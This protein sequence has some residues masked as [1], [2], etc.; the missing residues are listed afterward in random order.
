M[1]LVVTNFYMAHVPLNAS[2]NL[3]VQ[4]AGVYAV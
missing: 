3:A 4:M 2:K 1:S